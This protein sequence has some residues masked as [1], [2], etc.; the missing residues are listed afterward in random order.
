MEEQITI[1]VKEYDALLEDSF[2]L[3]CLERAG[4]SNWDGYEVAQEM[5]DEEVE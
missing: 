1:S 5:R 2:F 4:V 3:M